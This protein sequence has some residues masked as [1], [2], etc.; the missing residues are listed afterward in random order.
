MSP[1]TIVFTLGVVVLIGVAILALAQPDEPLILWGA[2]ILL[3]VFVCA[4]LIASSP[5]VNT[6]FGA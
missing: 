1:F 3:L 6:I 4:L 2:G 5:I